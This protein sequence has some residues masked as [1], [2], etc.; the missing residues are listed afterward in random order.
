MLGN[1]VH[2]DPPPGGWTRESLIAQIR[3]D[4]EAEGA[5][6]DQAVH[7]ILR[8]LREQDRRERSGRNRRRRS[9]RP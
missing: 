5:D 3:K 2:R 4:A 6:P 1:V 9:S 8:A 7:D